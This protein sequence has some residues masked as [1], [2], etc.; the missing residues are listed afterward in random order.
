MVLRYDGINGNNWDFNWLNNTK[1]PSLSEGPQDVI[2]LINWHKLDPPDKWEVDRNNY[3][4]SI[5]GNRNPFIDHPEYLN[6]IDMNDLTKLLPTYSNEPENHITNF[7]ASAGVNS[8]TVSWT[9]ALAGSQAPSG[10]LL[11]VFSYDNYFTP[12]DGETYNDYTDLQDYSSHL[13]ILYSSSDRYTFSPLNSNST[14]YFTIYPYFGAGSERNYK[15]DD[16]V[17]RIAATTLSAPTSLSAGDIVIVGFNMDDPDEFA[18]V[19]LVGLTSGTEIKFTDNGWFA[20]GG[21]R[22]T[23]DKITYTA[24]STYCTWNCDPL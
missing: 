21:F 22:A 1:L 23:V 5:Q 24:P 13:N 19:P 4:Q 15:T 10:Y 7:T 2:T 20:A 9:D 18:F 3:I 11:E 12:I 17:P 14:Y 16:T 8:I 6:F